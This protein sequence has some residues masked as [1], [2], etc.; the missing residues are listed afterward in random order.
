MR[1][2]CFLDVGDLSQDV[3]SKSR[4]VNITENK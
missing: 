2:E 1:P 4:E 3:G